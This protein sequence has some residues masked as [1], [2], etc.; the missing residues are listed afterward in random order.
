MSQNSYFLHLLVLAGPGL[1]WDFVGSGWDFVGP[2]DG[3]DRI[4]VSPICSIDRL[5]RPIGD[6]VWPDDRLESLRIEFSIGRLDLSRVGQSNRS[7]DWT[8][9][10]PRCP[11]DQS[12]F[13]SLVCFH[14]ASFDASSLVSFAFYEN[15]QGGLDVYPAWRGKKDRILK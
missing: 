6:F 4:G 9:F 3:S 10:F 11:I 2:V 7:S 14:V 1:G 8:L 12:D 5:T 13:R 15:F